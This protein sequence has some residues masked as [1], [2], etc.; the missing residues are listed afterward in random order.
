VCT[1]LHSLRSD[2]EAN[3]NIACHVC[4]LLHTLLFESEEPPGNLS[5]ESH[6]YNLQHSVCR[7]L[8]TETEAVDLP[9][10]NYRQPVHGQ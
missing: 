9:L 1:L 7:C 2:S 10:M 8:F 4:T 6:G 5:N 3:R